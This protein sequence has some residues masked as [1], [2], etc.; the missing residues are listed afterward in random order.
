MW[1]CVCVVVG[2][3]CASAAAVVP[4]GGVNC[5]S[6]QQCVGSACE[7]LPVWAGAYCEWPLQAL[8]SGVAVNGTLVNVYDQAFFALTLST[9]VSLL[10][11]ELAPTPGTSAAVEL[12][13]SQ[14][15]QPTPFSFQFAN[16]SAVPGAQT[17][18]LAFPNTGVWVAL[19]LGLASNSSFSIVAT[20]STVC[21][22]G[23]SGHG[24]CG[25]TTSGVCACA[26]GWSLADCSLPM[27]TLSN[28]TASN[29]TAVAAGAWSFFQL[30]VGATTQVSVALAVVD[31][32]AAAAGVA[33]RC[34]GS[35]CAALPAPTAS[36]TGVAP[37]PA[38]VVAIAFVRAG[39][40]P[41]QLQYDASAALSTAT[42]IEI[43][44]PTSGVVYYV[45]VLA[46]AA[47]TTVT[48]T[49]SF[50]QLCANGCSGHGACVSVAPGN[51]TCACDEDWGVNAWDCSVYEAPLRQNETFDGSVRAGEWRYYSLFVPLDKNHVTFSCNLTSPSNG[52]TFSLFINANARPTLY[53]YTQR[54]PPNSTRAQV[55]L[56]GTAVAGQWYVG[57]YGEARGGGGAVA[58][59]AQDEDDGAQYQLRL[60][61]ASLCP[62][63]CSDHGACVQN[64]CNCL[65]GYVGDDCSSE[66]LMLTA[67]VPFRGSVSFNTWNY[68]TI[69]VQEN[70]LE[71]QVNETYNNFVV[72]LV[73]VYARRVQ[74][75]CAGAAQGHCLPT[76]NTFDVANTSA[77]G[78]HA[79]YIPS[80]LANGTWNVGV[81]GSAAESARVDAE[82]VI[83]AYVGCE[84]YASCELCAQDPNCGWCARDT[85]HGSCV[86][87]DPQGTDKTGSCVGWFFAHCENTSSQKD[88]TLT[89]TVIGISV[90]FCVVFGI[91]VA[92]VVFWWKQQ[93]RKN[94]SPL[95]AFQAGDSPQRV[96]LPAQ[97]Q[98]QSMQSARASGSAPGSRDASDD[99]GGSGILARVGRSDHL[100]RAQQQQ[101]QLQQQDD[102]VV[103][104]GFGRKPAFEQ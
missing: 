41:S 50:G 24:A 74:A 78:V 14:G 60:S 30:Q 92:F 77:T 42:T 23:C 81:T 71:I 6:H 51:A 62:Q 46:T 53:A 5:T 7:C 101:Q 10:T 19:V 70:A 13:L 25:Q 18:S 34:A 83:A 69:T 99:G 35:A 57:V 100:R 36:P 102:E 59:S 22:N 55:T 66:R 32:T 98:P 12:F 54:A 39:Q 93:Q 95:G 48:V 86:A 27:V 68:Y 84:R 29:A 90:G 52:T 65:A 58:A 45:G 15:A 49:A 94:R 82:Y 20:P 56:S 103:E 80:Q 9:A 40:L 88:S 91:S 1:W 37:V 76:S 89:G 75:S 3:V 26:A 8:S 79:I 47:A 21:P 67:G 72:G 38:P 44:T 63:R 73:W 31:T 61:M 11:V 104:F 97:P 87:G 96:R 4:C 43:D 2:L 64:H 33:G 85:L 28:A 16:S 17:I